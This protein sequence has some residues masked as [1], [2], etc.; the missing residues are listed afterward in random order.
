MDPMRINFVL[1]VANL[2]GG[3]RVVAIYAQRLAARGHHVTVVSLPRRLDWR[4]RL[5]RGFAG[6][7][8]GSHSPSARSHLDGIDLDHRVL[9]RFRP[10]VDADLPDAHVTIATWWKTAGWVNH[11][12][13]EKGAKA[14]FVQHDERQV[15]GT[16]EQVIPTWR[17]AMHKILVAQWL[18][19]VLREQGVSAD[20]SV[21]PN[22]VDTAQFFAPP[23]GKQAVPTV[24]LMYSDSRFKGVDLSLAAY[25]KAREQIPELKLIAF[26]VG[27][28]KDALPL[29]AGAEYH[30]NPSQEKLR[31]YYGGCDAWLF[32]SRCEGFG[33]P[34]LEAMA[35]RTPVIATPAGAAPEL[36]GSGGV[37]VGAEDVDGMAAA[38]LGVCGRSE[39]DWKAMS[40][41]AHTTATG[42]TWDDAT[43]RFE[44]ALRQAVSTPSGPGTI[45]EP[46]NHS[47]DGSDGRKELACTG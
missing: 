11:L 27:E 15:H 9:E 45:P 39:H 16:D 23:R 47:E 24:G 40:D 30:A 41:Q 36:V 26:G 33:L 43:D 42:Y 13:P 46:G 19:P 32:G 25:K 37:L 4:R 18:E 14:Y 44:A 29:P 20:V 5:R 12:S 17:M 22:A 35:C 7:G 28:P 38:I 31:E 3:V 10:V 21:V 6:R 2:A 1:P 34:I 8:F